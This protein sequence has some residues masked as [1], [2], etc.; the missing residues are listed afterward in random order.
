MDDLFVG[1]VVV[2]DDDDMEPVWFGRLLCAGILY[3]GILSR[4]NMAATDRKRMSA[5]N[6]FPGWQKNI[7]SESFF[8]SWLPAALAGNQ[9]R[10]LAQF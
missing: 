1:V 6:L 8:D 5:C 9:W 10:F 2:V 4:N 3:E 7:M